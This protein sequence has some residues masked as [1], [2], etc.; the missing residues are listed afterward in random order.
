[1]KTSRKRNNLNG[2][3]GGAP[4]TH[5]LQ[6]GTLLAQALS[7]PSRLFDTPRPRRGPSRRGRGGTPAPPG[8]ACGRSAAGPRH[9]PNEALQARGE[10][11]SACPGAL[12]SGTCEKKK[13]QR[14]GGPG[15]GG[16]RRPSLTRRGGPRLRSFPPRPANDRHDPETFPAAPPGLHFP[17]RPAPSAGCCRGGRREVT[18]RP[19]VPPG[20][21]VSPGA[22][23]WGEAVFPPLPFPG[24]A[25][26]SAGAL[27][28]ARRGLR[29]A[30]PPREDGAGGAGRGGPAL[31]RAEQAAG[32]RPRGV[33]ADGA[34]PGGVRGLPGE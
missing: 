23:R 15:P 10:G 30:P 25:P 7:G 13:R 19:R 9:A 3:V 4:P 1:M 33:A 31:R 26:V 8:R 17:A 6:P 22:L 14:S 24:P 29:D 32:P 2:S 20:S 12:R 18:G 21:V 16:P 27:P 28:G 5:P 11:C 34:A